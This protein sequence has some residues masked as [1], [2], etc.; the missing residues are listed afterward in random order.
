MLGRRVSGCSQRDHLLQRWKRGKEKRKALERNEER[1]P[2]N[3]SKGKVN[4]R[5]VGGQRDK[6]Y[7]KKAGT[8]ARK[9]K[10]A[11]L[12]T[13]NESGERKEGKA[14]EAVRKYILKREIQEGAEKRRQRSLEGTW[15]KEHK[16]RNMKEERG[17]TGR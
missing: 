2:R 5:N 4:E 17:E 16:G 8:E 13:E 11:R 14:R 10:S 3:G 1:E 15:G 9:N 6:D 12:G 7:C